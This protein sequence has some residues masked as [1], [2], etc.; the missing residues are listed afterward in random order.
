MLRIQFVERTDSTHYTAQMSGLAP[1]TSARLTHN[2]LY[3]LKVL[4]LKVADPDPHSI[5]RI[6]RLFNDVAAAEALD[7]SHPGYP[8]PVHVSDDM[9]DFFEDH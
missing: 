9:P 1:Y 7:D 4:C 8:E 2:T 5:A 6:D 3:S